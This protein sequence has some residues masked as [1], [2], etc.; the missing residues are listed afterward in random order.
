MTSS[1]LFDLDGTL[2][3]TD[4]AHFS[5]FGEVFAPYGVAIDWNTYRTKIMGA[6]NVAITTEFLSHVP[7]SEHGAIMER[8]E[9]L[10]RE[11]LDVLES[12][13]GVTELLRFA[14]EAGISCAVVT[15]APRLNADLVLG[16]LNLADRF[17]TVV[18]GAE[19]ASTKPHPLPYLE[20][21][22]R[23]GTDASTSV[24]FEDSRSG[25]TSAHAA[26]LAVVGMTTSLDAATLRSLGASI[27]VKDFND[28]AVMELV[29]SRC[30]V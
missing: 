4:Q 1:F 24:A 18:I 13:P 27:A 10:Y 25:V 5:A 21:L 26:G 6:H 30:K 2:V 16:A 11:R 14:E 20:G 22:R 9:A 17:A 3:D 12:L 23:L 29:R 28:P 15:N 7:A 8:K 19:L